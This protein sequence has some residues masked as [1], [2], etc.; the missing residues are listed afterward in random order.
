MMTAT[1]IGLGDI[2]PQ[3][4]AGRLYGIVHMLASVLLFRLVLETIVDGYERWR[5]SIRKG[6]MLRKQLDEKLIAALD[7]DGSGV[8][9][10]EF[11]LGML[12]TLGVLQ[13]GDYEPFLEQFAR[14]DTNG[15]GRLSRDDLV[16]LTAAKRREVAAMRDAARHDLSYELRVQ[17]NATVL[18]V[19]ALLA[20]F[21][22]LWY[23]AFGYC[24]LGGGLC[25]ALAIGNMIGCAP[26]RA[27]HRRSIVLLLLGLL[28]FCLSAF[29]LISYLV[30]P[31]AVLDNDS[32]IETCLLGSLDYVTGATV[33]IE[34]GDDR[35]AVIAY[36]KT[37]V[38]DARTLVLLVPYFAIFA[39]SLILHL[40]TI[41]ICTKAMAASKTEGDTLAVFVG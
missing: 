41:Y 13:R 35:E 15:D 12:Q 9:R 26:G 21:G 18:M 33:R 3:S 37:L 19:P 16:A 38:H 34:P 24:L 14:L 2:A 6:E 1:T 27:K 20:S 8:D 17:E 7:K 22:F 29:I 39:Y 31:K 10:A 4:Q 11:V 28:C 32:L 40:H 25:H 30:D 36:S 5:Q 23:S